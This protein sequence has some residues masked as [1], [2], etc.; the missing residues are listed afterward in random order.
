MPSFAFIN[1]LEQANNLK[2][3]GLNI[4]EHSYAD[5]FNFAGDNGNFKNMVV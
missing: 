4:E 5:E 1:R 2:E 3:D